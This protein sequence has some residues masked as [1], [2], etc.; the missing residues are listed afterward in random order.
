LALSALVA[1]LP[2]ALEVVAGLWRV[3]L[4]EVPLVP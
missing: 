1:T 2:F 3:T 4:A